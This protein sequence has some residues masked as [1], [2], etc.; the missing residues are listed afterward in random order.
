MATDAAAGKQ[1][2]RARGETRGGVEGLAPTH[3]A[4]TGIGGFAPIQG[5]MDRDLTK[6]EFQRFHDYIYKVAG[7]HYPNEKI[8]LL[9]N[10]I[11]KRLRATNCASFDAY[12]TRI[13]QRGESAEQQQFF[14]SITTNETY[15]FRCQRHWDFFK[16]W[17][18]QRYNDPQTRKQPIRIWSAASSTG[19][20]AFTALI[21]LQQVYGPGFG[22]TQVEVVGTD[23]SNAVLD[24]ARKGVFSAYAVSQTP[25][26]VVKK[27]F[28]K[29]DKEDFLFDRQLA[30]HATFSRHNLMEP[31]AGKGTFDFVFV[32]NVLI[33]FDA[34]SREQVLKNCFTV[35]NPGAPLLVGESESL[36]GTKHPFQYLKPSIFVKA[37]TPAAAP[38][39]GAAAATGQKRPT[40]AK[41]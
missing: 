8:E 14:D 3:C 29:F 38:A 32:R 31:L 40:P 26:D 18:Q 5:A 13:Q 25:P 16:D 41:A 17:A 10:R 12:L 2:L 35:M 19:A 1:E 15:F 11:R 6:D 30:R 7:I 22:G 37:A 28:S 27:F 39:A 21:V 33:Y 20:E 34:P 36:M 24:E 9:S 23:L 4:P